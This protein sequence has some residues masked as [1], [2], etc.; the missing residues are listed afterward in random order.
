MW[1]RFEVWVSMLVCIWCIFCCVSDRE[2]PLAKVFFCPKKTYTHARSPWTNIKLPTHITRHEFVYEAEF[3]RIA[4]GNLSFIFPYFCLIME[5]NESYFLRFT[6][7]KVSSNINDRVF[8]DFIKKEK[9][10]YL[11][12]SI[13]GRLT[14]Y[15]VCIPL[16]GNFSLCGN[17]V[18]ILFISSKW[19]ATF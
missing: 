17:S 3:N 10:L 1:Q 12:D 19:L 6:Q 16:R 14:K 18:F 13:I 7:H 8:S 2:S 11:G 9:T 4:A 5:N 15:I